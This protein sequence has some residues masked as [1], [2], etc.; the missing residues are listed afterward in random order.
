MSCITLVI[1]VMGYL[2]TCCRYLLIIIFTVTTTEELTDVHLLGICVR[3]AGTVGLGRYAHIAV[4]R[5][6]DA[7]A[8]RV[9]LVFCMAAALYSSQRVF[10]HRSVQCLGR[11]YLSGDVIAA[12]YMVHKDIVGSMLTVDMYVGVASDIRHT[13]TSEHLSVRI[14]QR[15]CCTLVENGT[16]VT[17][18][19]RHARRAL[20]HSLVAAAIYVTANLYL[21]LCYDC[22]QE[23]KYQYG[24][25]AS[26]Y[27]L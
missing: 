19:H 15:S 13:G 7:V 20:H 24:N 27:I 6:V 16:D 1:D 18:F 12:I 25:N 11:A 23:C 4:K 9:D 26:H 14:F 10:R 2:T 21:P 17:G 8:L 5:V 22:A 3:I